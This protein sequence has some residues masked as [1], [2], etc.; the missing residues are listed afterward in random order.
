MMC[1]STSDLSVV[2][3]M[4]FFPNYR[5][6]L[7]WHLASPSSNRFQPFRW[8]GPTVRTDHP[9]IIDPL[10]TTYVTKIFSHIFL[11]IYG[12]K[13][14]AHRVW[15]LTGYES[16]LGTLR[17]RLISAAFWHTYSH[18]NYCCT[19]IMRSLSSCQ[20]GTGVVDGYIGLV[21]L[22]YGSQESDNA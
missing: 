14:F 19:V 22:H 21:D 4:Q 8:S 20:H 10:Y 2:V 9:I 6:T 12:R 1:R 3:W 15:G 11:S 13:S 5:I 7:T 16:E 17:H 18:G